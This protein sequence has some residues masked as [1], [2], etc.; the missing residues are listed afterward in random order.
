VLRA[1]VPRALMWGTLSPLSNGI[2]R[3]PAAGVN[4]TEVLRL[5]IPS[6]RCIRAFSYAPRNQT[7]DRTHFLLNA[8][9]FG[10]SICASSWSIAVW[11]VFGGQAEGP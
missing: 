11:S 1:V 7:R 9:S 2:L 4:R 5:G 6:G 3:P 8:S 10:G